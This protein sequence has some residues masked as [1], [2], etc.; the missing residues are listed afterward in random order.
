MKV[1][2]WEMKYAG[3]EIVDMC[4]ICEL[5]KSYPS[6]GVRSSYEND[7]LILDV[8]SYYQT[9]AALHSL[10]YWFNKLKNEKIDEILIEKLSEP[11]NKI[12]ITDYRTSTI[13]YIF[14]P[15]EKESVKLRELLYGYASFLSIEK[16]RKGEISF[17]INIYFIEIEDNWEER[18]VKQNGLFEYEDLKFLSSEDASNTFNKKIRNAFGRARKGEANGIKIICPFEKIE[19]R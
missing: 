18:I 5:G 8:K 11:E 1:E 12:D 3:I 17:P 16:E 19:L 6:H 2:A 15:D 9:T 14:V 13:N 7:I 10:E 4:E